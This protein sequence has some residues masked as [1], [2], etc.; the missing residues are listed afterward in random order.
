MSAAVDR[1]IRELG[2]IDVLAVNHGVATIGGG[3]KQPDALWDVVIENT[4]RRELLWHSPAPRV[5]PDGVPRVPHRYRR[6][7]DR[8][9]DAATAGSCWGTD[10]SPCGVTVQG[11]ST[12]PRAGAFDGLP[13]PLRAA[14]MTGPSPLA[15]TCQGFITTTEEFLHA[16]QREG[17]ARSEIRARNLF[18][19]ALATSWAQGAA[20]ADHASAAALAGLIR[21]GWESTTRTGRLS[22]VTDSR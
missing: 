7:G 4:P 18:L 17:S 19:A 12:S 10:W 20:M 16:A 8:R 1:A 11:S 22:G 15:V 14:T 13:E 5:R 9:G 3:D 6:S 21:T 2:R